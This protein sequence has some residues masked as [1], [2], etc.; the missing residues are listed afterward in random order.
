MQLYKIALLVMLMDVKMSTIVGILTFVNMIFLAFM[1][2]IRVH[3]NCVVVHEKELEPIVYLREWK[4]LI[5][6][7]P[8]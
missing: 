5:A 4:E 2:T 6:S 1:N 3:A 7:G 8:E